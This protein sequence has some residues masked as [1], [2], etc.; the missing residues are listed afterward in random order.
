MGIIVVFGPPGTGKTTTLAE[1]I[2]KAI[3]RYRDENALLVASLTNT[4]A[5]EIAGRDLPVNPRH[6]GT[7]HALC[8]RSMGCPPLVDDF[9]EEWNVENPKLTLSQNGMTTSPEEDSQHGGERRTKAAEG[10]ALREHVSLLRHKQMPFPSWGLK[11]QEFFERWTAFKRRHDAVDF[12][13]MIEFGLTMSGPPFGVRLGV[14]DE[15]QDFS[16]LEWAVVQHW[17]SM[18]DYA[19]V[20]GDDCQALY[21]W[22][23]ANPESFIHMDPAPIEK[24]ILPQSYRLPHRIQAYC[25]HWAE[26]IMVR[27]PK[28]YAPREEPGQLI[29]STGLTYVQNRPLLDIYDRAVRENKT[30][31]IMGACGYHLEPTIALLREHGIPF[32]NRWRTKNGAWNPLLRK[33][34]STH[35]ADRVAA[36]LAAYRNARL[37]W[38][39]NELKAWAPLVLA[40]E[41]FQR[42][43]K[44]KIDALD[45][46]DALIPF[47]QLTT[48][49]KPE[50]ID[51]ALSGNPSWLY[52]H[53]STA[54]AKSLAFP[55]A[56]ARRDPEL[57]TEAP[58][59]FVGTIHSFK[60]AQAD[61]VVL[62][63]D[64]S[65]AGYEEYS[66]P[67]AERDSV[68]RQYYVGLSRAYD[69]LIL[70]SAE[71]ASQSVT[72]LPT[73]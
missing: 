8:Y 19:L 5:Q 32:S 34:K 72:W 14:F 52:S 49:L 42:G 41:V 30:L 4:A 22:R 45:P 47:E 7:L 18:M 23:G 59:V 2:R 35:T 56:I 63:P 17:T 62:Y 12:D 38:T 48:I 40:D 61:I 54:A 67:N 13:D 16:K 1:S 21:T 9:L 60:G 58:R 28:T 39:V 66:R 20:A 73:A 10:D 25:E 44:T 33:R 50:V 36:Y 68:F 27:E 57:L 24:R 64:L 3:A 15:C 6:I 37:S 51:D 69:T 71:S 43:Q 29:H 65:P 53:A 46:S 31:M 70:A 26:R 55:V 11:N